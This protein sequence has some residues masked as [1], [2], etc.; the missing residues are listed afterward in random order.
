MSKNNQSTVLC[1][2]KHVFVKFDRLEILGPFGEYVHIVC[3]LEY[4][5]EFWSFDLLIVFRT[6]L[7]ILRTLAFLAFVLTFETFDNFYHFD[8]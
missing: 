6:I 4:S 1:L 7:R 2:L 5:L 8:F 3:I